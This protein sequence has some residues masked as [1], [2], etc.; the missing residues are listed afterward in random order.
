MPVILDDTARGVWL[1]TGAVP[2]EELEAVLVPR[3]PD[4]MVLVIASEQFVNY[5]ADDPRCVEP[6]E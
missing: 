5:G 6:V 2:R 3:R 1:R 4:D